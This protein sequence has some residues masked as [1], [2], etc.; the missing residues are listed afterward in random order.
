MW[1]IWAEMLTNYMS[2]D[3]FS[4]L[5]YSKKIVLLSD[6]KQKTYMIYEKDFLCP[7]SWNGDQP[8]R[9]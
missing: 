7:L 1:Q 5:L 3:Y 6:S 8:V 9:K 2:N 4:L